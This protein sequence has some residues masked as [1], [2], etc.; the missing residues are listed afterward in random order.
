MARSYNCACRGSC[1]QSCL[2]EVLNRKGTEDGLHSCRGEKGDGDGG[3][4]DD[5]NDNGYDGGIDGD[6]DD[7]DVGNDG[8]DD[9][10]DCSHWDRRRRRGQK[11]GRLLPREE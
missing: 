10:D 7:C 9:N 4:D 1:T 5:Y 3:N 6:D 11:G 8:D 2:A